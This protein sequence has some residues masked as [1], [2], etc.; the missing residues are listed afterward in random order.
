MADLTHLLEALQDEA[1][2]KQ[3]EVKAAQI[4][5]EALR[6]A[7][8]D[9]LKKVSEAQQ[10][11]AARQ[12]GIDEARST[13]NKILID[14]RELAG[15]IVNKA[16]V[17]RRSV[18]VLVVDA[19]RRAA[20]IIVDAQEQV[21]DLNRQINAKRNDLKIVNDA[22]ATAAHKLA[23]IKKQAKDFAGP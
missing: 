16:D 4:Q 1:K 2:A 13:A 22:I 14:A 12:T 17:A 5:L 21:I 10:Q 3:A 19:E 18:D 9:T 11:L 7:H 23:E 6:S 8:K 20:K 15:G